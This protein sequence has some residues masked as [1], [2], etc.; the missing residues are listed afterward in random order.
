[1]SFL[2]QNRVTDAVF[3]HYY[4]EGDKCKTCEVCPCRL[5]TFQKMDKCDQVWTMGWTIVAIVGLILFYF[6][7]RQVLKF[8]VKVFKGDLG[9]PEYGSINVGYFKNKL[10]E[11]L[12]EKE[13]KASGHA[14]WQFK[15]LGQ[16]ENQLYA[17]LD[18]LCRSTPVPNIEMIGHHISIYDDKEV[19]ITRATHPQDTISEIMQKFKI[20]P[21]KVLW[22]KDIELDNLDST[23]MEYGVPDNRK[24]DLVLKERHVLENQDMEEIF[25]NL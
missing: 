16:I 7:G 4:G 5:S 3:K 25:Q 11:R 8:M 1:M 9:L 18:W 14:Q 23:L 6:F 24:V 12:L 17:P 2:F 15:R 21:K 10:R 19:H 20:S 13:K 22:Y